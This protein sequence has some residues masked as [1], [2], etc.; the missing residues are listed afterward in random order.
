[1]RGGP[2][3]RVSRERLGEEINSSSNLNDVFER[4]ERRYKE[5]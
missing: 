4:N 2:R 3:G 5:Y 1:V